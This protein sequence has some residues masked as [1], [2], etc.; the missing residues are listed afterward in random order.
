MKIKN[1]FPKAS[2]VIVNF[3]N[4]NYLEKCI[5]SL[6]NQSYQNIEM[7]IVDDKST[8]NSQEI[9]K[10]YKKK[11]TIIFNKKK[12][13]KGSYNQI[14]CYY[15][16]YLKS[17]GKY[18]FFLD[19]DDYFKKKKVELLVKQFQKDEK[20]D[21]IFDLPIFKFKNREVKKKFIQKKFI[22][23][24]W[25]RFSPQSCISIRKSFAKEVFKELSIKKFETL[26]FDFRIAVYYFL[27]KKQLYIFK[28]YLT[29][30]RQL[31]NSASKKYKIFN[32]NW[33][34]RRKQ[35]HEFVSYINKKLNKKDTLNIDKILT[36]IMNL[37]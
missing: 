36:N 9:I 11:A 25:P 7:I 23:S 31:D 14:N 5:Q 17:K 8:D 16:G 19:S 29:Y 21:L 20:I 3:N 26:W 4:A 1:K 6:L 10:R 35:A 24:S 12:T 13:S 32:K 28:K 22:F 18:L 27:K 30:Y 34:H 33:W 2:V 37:F 15:R